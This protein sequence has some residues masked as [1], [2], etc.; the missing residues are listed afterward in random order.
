MQAKTRLVLVD[1][2]WLFRELIIAALKEDAAEHFEIVGELKS[3]KDVLLHAPV[4]DPDLILVDTNL[5]AIGLDKTVRGLRQVLPTTRVAVLTS[6][7]S[8][9]D[10]DTALR[11][12]AQGYLLKSAGPRRLLSML[13]ALSRGEY[14]VD[15][16]LQSQVG[17][18]SAAGTHRFVAA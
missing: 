13:L 11:A 1:N 12:G 5:G 6:S 17:S 4:L 9:A 7:E 16:K 18:L 10:F 8:G 3:G 14:V 15:P 2:D